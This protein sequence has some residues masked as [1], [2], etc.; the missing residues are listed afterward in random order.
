M[1]DVG[2]LSPLEIELDPLLDQ[3][4]ACCP[5]VRIQSRRDAE[6]AEVGA[7]VGDLAELNEVPAVGLA[8]VGPGHGESI[9]G[10][11]QVQRDRLRARR[12]RPATGNALTQAER[13]R[14]YRER[15]KAKL[16]ALSTMPL[17][18]EKAEERI[19][20]LDRENGALAT[21]AA[22]L[23]REIRAKDVAIE[24]LS[25]RLDDLTADLE[26]LREHVA[27]WREEDGSE[28]TEAPDRP[29]SRRGRGAEVHIKL[30]DQRRSSGSRKLSRKLARGKK[31][32]VSL[33][34]WSPGGTP[35]ISD[36]AG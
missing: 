5:C 18:D 8:I 35:K 25:K 7:Q 32:L 19:A 15:R 3:G 21:K 30:S 33:G 6:P 36:S 10:D 11:R 22:R 14:R 34:H 4:A 28:T 27:T 20:E 23:E 12:G 26:Y 1:R 9:R 13:Q 2:W 16:D 17:G 29:K 31:P 24:R